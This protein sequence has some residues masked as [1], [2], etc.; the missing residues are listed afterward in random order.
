MR[1]T[2]GLTRPRISVPWL[3]AAAAVALLG[4][5]VARA[6]PGEAR[7]PWYDAALEASGKA[8]LAQ[9]VVLEALEE[10]G[11]GPVPEDLNGTGLIGLDWTVLTTSLGQLEAKRT[12]LN[13]DF[14]ALLVRLYTEAGLASGDA[15][16]IGASGSFP[17]LTVASLAAADAL[18]LRARVIA[19]VGASMYG[20]TRPEM[21]IADILLLLQEKAVLEFS[22][23]AVSPGGDADRGGGGIVEGGR[24]AI[25]Q[26]A[27]SA[28]VPVILEDT[29]GASVARRL[30]LYGDDVRLFV[31]VGGASPNMGET[32]DSLRLPPG[33]LTSVPTLPDGPDRGLLYEYAARGVPVIHLLNIRALAAQYGL[34]FDPVP[35]PRPGSAT[36]YFRI[37]YPRLIPA[38][39]AG[40]ALVCLYIGVSSHRKRQEFTESNPSLEA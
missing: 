36:L 2:G 28:G 26:E 29:L 19:S 5:A 8:A 33:L 14:A 4:L 37:E 20:A 24:A 25:L 7:Q 39:G 22:L 31:N 6:F 13:P 9:R 11:L 18:G 27:E 1:R 21:S 16:A 12:S 17:A 3:A 34:P 30:A 38:L 40:A 10:R 23:L 15:V 35:L 32:A